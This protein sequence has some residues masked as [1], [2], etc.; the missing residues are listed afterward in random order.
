MVDGALERFGLDED[1][2]RQTGPRRRAA[3]EH[4]MSRSSP[5]AL[6]V[7]VAASLG[8]APA[9]AGTCAAEIAQLRQSLHQAEKGGTGVV[10]SAPQSIDAQLEHQPTPASVERAKKNAKTQILALLAEA[11][12]FDARGRRRECRQALIRANLLLNP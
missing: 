3:L 10:G 9:S 4:R 11:E 1:R 12:S 5:I 8:A 6:V 2:P 7:A